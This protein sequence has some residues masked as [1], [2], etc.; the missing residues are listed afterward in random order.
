MT[1]EIVSLAVLTAMFPTT[2]KATLAT[3]LAPLNK[4][5]DQFD[6]ES[7]LR[8]AGFLA[9]VGHES[10]GFKFVKENLNYSSDALRR[11]FS[12]YFPTKALA[13]AYARKP[14]KIAARVY[15]GR[16]GNGVE[17]TGD[18]WKFRGRGLI[19]LT[20]KNNYAAFAADMKMTLDEAVAYL[21]TTEGAVMGAGWFWSKNGLN[22]LADRADII[23]MTKRI[24]GGTNGL[25]DRKAYYAKARKL[26]G[27]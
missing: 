20:G 15:G 22:A 13:D 21:E 18:G 3:F 17:A 2:P 27:V 14:E 12:K 19:Q 26:L 8:A 9:Q 23:G 4:T 16:M 5:L 10:G 25:D 7:G 6:I 11:V 24:N 1:K